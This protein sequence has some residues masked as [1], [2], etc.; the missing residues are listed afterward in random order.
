MKQFLVVALVVLSACAPSAPTPTAAPAAL[1]QPTA[2]PTAT[3]D[4][5]RELDA[6][7]MF[8]FPMPAGYLPGEIEHQAPSLYVEKGMPAAKLAL[9]VPITHPNNYGGRV[10]VF[11]YEDQ[12]ARDNAYMTLVAAM[13]EGTETV[14][15]IGEHATGK[16]YMIFETELAFVRCK[17]VVDILRYEDLEIAA[18]VEN[19]QHLDEDL[20]PVVCP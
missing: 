3:P 10:T 14:P 11:V 16:K 6:V 19:A 2:L 20:Q 17:A 8:P 12:A 9:S 15:G 13:K 1:P 7:L 4:P 5:Y 18:L